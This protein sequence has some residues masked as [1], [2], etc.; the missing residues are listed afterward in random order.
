M[1]AGSAA[2]ARTAAAAAVRAT[3]STSSGGS[4]AGPGVLGGQTQGEPSGPR[5][6]LR[7]A[8]RGAR[9]KRKP[10]STQEA[11]W[12]RQAAAIK[13]ARLAVAAERKRRPVQVLGPQRKP[14]A[15]AAH[16]EDQCR[17]D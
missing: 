16:D 14:L 8:Q 13:R 11:K 17:P 10:K 15:R 9:P 6:D 1:S 2:V 12:A 5:P 4:G 3:A 7:R